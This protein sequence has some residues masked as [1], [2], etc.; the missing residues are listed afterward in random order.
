MDVN[1]NRFTQYCDAIITIVTI[2]KTYQIM[3]D[4]FVDWWAKCW[5]CTQD[6]YDQYSCKLSFLCNAFEIPTIH[7]NVIG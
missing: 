4:L 3:I 2:V 7:N 6:T 1:A 5:K